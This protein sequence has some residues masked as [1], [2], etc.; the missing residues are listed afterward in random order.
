MSDMQG[1]IPM[2]MTCSRVATGL[3]AFAA[4][5]PSVRAQTSGPCP[6]PCEAN[7]NIIAGGAMPVGLVIY[8][9]PPTDGLGRPEC[10]TCSPCQGRIA[11]DFVSTYGECFTVLDGYDQPPPGDPPPN[12]SPPSSNNNS[13]QIRLKS[14]CD[15]PYPDEAHIRTGDCSQLPASSFYSAEFQLYCLCMPQ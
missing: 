6:N 15:D 10:A 5:V 7:L 1:A 13:G 9:I 2:I 8:V 4:L 11:W 3:L 12:W 14:I